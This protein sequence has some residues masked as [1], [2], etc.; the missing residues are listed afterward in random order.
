MFNS[1][2][3]PITVHGLVCHDHVDMACKG[4]ASLLKFSVASVQL[5]VHDDGSLTPEDVEKLQSIEGAKVICRAEADELMNPLLKHHPNCYNIRYEHPMFLKLLDT[6]LLSD[7]DFAYCDTDILFF[8]PFDG[9]FQ[10]PNS[11][12]SA[13]FMQDYLEAYSVFP[14]HLLGGSKLKL[15]SKVNAGLMFVRKSAY[16]LDFVEWFLG[17]KEFRSKPV[18]KMEQTCWAALGYRMGCQ[19]WNPEQI[20]LMRPDSVLTE[21]LV[22]GHFVK[23]VRYLLNKFYAH[24]QIDLNASEKQPIVVQ[25]IASQDCDVLGLAKNHIKRQTN[26]V[27]SHRRKLTASIHQKA[28]W[29]LAHYN[30][31]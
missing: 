19:L 18:H 7:G 24:T 28:T 8:Q 12:V 27:Q 2:T 16:D 30:F 15:P 20:V 3:P 21:Q 14:W 11:Q 4:F 10:W 17:K 25:T 22:A 23:E 13:I 31:M 26:R 5:V 29:R 1:I 6:A 9:M